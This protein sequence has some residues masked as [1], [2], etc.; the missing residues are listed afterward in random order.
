MCMAITISPWFV[1]LAYWFA[2]VS[3]LFLT[4]LLAGLDCYLLVFKHTHRLHWVHVNALYA[5][6]CTCLLTNFVSYVG[7]YVGLYVGW[8]LPN[9]IACYLCSHFDDTHASLLLLL[10]SS[11]S[12]ACMCACIRMHIIISHLVFSYWWFVC[13][14]ACSRSICMLIYIP[15]WE[16]I[17]VKFKHS[18]RLCL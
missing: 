6:I 8:L 3:H 17:G 15:D 12:L 18:T 14:F 1:S 10:G 7:Q 2:C 11:L 4:K 5:H 16:W 13:V 9:W